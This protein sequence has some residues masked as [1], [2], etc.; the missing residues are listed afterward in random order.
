M[1]ASMLMNRSIRQDRAKEKYIFGKER[2]L[3]CVTSS[4]CLFGAR[5]IIFHGNDKDVPETVIS[6]FLAA[7]SR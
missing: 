6:L 4:M 3:S 7:R 5:R 2:M 1:Q